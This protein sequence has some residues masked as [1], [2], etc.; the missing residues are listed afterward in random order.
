M[1]LRGGQ[2]CAKYYQAHYDEDDR[3]NRPKRSADFMD[4]GAGVAREM[5]QARHYEA[6]QEPSCQRDRR[7][8]QDKKQAH[9]QKRTAGSPSDSA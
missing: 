3:A 7:V 8:C 6:K 9:D 1:V 5:Q 4:L 2:S